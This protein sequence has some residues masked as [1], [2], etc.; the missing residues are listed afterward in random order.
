MDT[1]IINNIL[2]GVGISAILLG[3][4][5]DPKHTTK[6]QLIH[7]VKT[8]WIL[9]AVFCVVY[10]L[11]L[12]TIIYG[13][14]KND[15]NNFIF[16]K[17]KIF[18]LKQWTSKFPDVSKMIMTFLNDLING[19]KSRFNKW[20]NN[21]VS[22]ITSFFPKIGRWFKN[23]GQWFYNFLKPIVTSFYTLP[24]EIASWLITKSMDYFQ[25]Y[26]LGTLIFIAHVTRELVVAFFMKV[27]LLPANLAKDAINSAFPKW[28]KDAINGISAGGYDAAVNG[29]YN[30]VVKIMNPVKDE[31]KKSI[32]DVEFDDFY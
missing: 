16:D 3:K 18:D 12:N 28:A 26:I 15:K 10:I 19:I 30:T 5:M 14:V 27:I 7:S 9:K 11:F 17:L 29:A 4:Y 32:P 2:S 20:I 21:L 8:Q 6:F 13:N 23:L 22:Q 24:N 31:L 25:Y 1:Q